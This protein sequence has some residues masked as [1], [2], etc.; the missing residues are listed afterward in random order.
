M[1]STFAKYVCH[2]NSGNQ[3]SYVFK[4][5]ANTHI[6]CGVLLCKDVG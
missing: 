3:S 1:I 5:L 4:N 6:F 2:G